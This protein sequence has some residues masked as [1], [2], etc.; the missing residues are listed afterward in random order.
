MFLGNMNLNGNGGNF[1]NPNSTQY[2][3]TAADSEGLNCH[4]LFLRLC[5]RFAS[6]LDPYSPYMQLICT[7]LLWRRQ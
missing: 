2:K 4:A 1:F 7:M 3:G 5:L 6:C